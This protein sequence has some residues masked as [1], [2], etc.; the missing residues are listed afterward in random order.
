MSLVYAAIVPHPPLL[1]PS[2]GKE[3]ARMLVKTWE[4]YQVLHAG[5][6]T[7]RPD[8]ILV[9]TPHFGGMPDTFT[10]N[11]SPR[12]ATHFMEFGDFSP[13][14]NFCTDSLTVERI[15]HSARLAGHRVVLI[16]D[17]HLDYGSGVPL[18]FLPD[19]E[20]EPCVAIVSPTF[21]SGKA[22]FA[23]GQVLKEVILSSRRR[24][25]VICSGDLSHRLSSD[26]PAG[27]SP[28]AKDFDELMLANLGAGSASPVLQMEESFV[29]EAHACGYRPICMF[30]GM[31]ERMEYR[32]D[33]LSYE[34]PFGVGYC[35]MGFH[36]T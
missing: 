23:F 4:S 26:T 28:R 22:Q 7:A 19:A 27:F 32:A 13:P 34:A 6:R 3:H 25:A 21:G 29:A 15:R 31:L 17:E 20:T 12:Y 18:Y 35:T 10:L 36:L 24:I 2:I 11:S 14:R 1:L 9:I 16:A 5:L 8:T 30:L 33:L